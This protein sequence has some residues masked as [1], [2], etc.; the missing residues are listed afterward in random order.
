MSSSFP[1]SLHVDVIVLSLSY[2]CVCQMMND[3]IRSKFGCH[4][5][6]GNEAPGISQIQEWGGG[7]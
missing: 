5:T 2:G 6:N 4:I 7:G 1:M 3:I